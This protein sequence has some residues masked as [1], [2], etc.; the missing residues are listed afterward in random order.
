MSRNIRML[1]AG[2]VSLMVISAGGLAALM[3][4]PASMP[5][6]TS[7]LTG[8]IGGPFTLTS[9]DGRTVTDRTYRGKWLL[10]YFGYTSCP[11]AC[12]TALNNMGV[13]LDRLGPA[14]AAVQPIFITVDPKRDTQE[15]LAEYL[16]S[17]DPHIVALTGTADQISA[18]VKEYHVYVSAN[19]ESGGDYTVD[20]SSLYYLINPDGKFVN[21][22]PGN[23][24]GDDMA[25]LLRELTK[26]T[27]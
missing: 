4:I 11:D 15:A 19:S 17:F 20:H 21:V 18:V 24:A 25:N 14:A 27:V 5:K 3:L 9:A 10:I 22:M 26:H 13:A 23:L 8:A 6:I 7:S 2:A 16:K 12:P 1:L